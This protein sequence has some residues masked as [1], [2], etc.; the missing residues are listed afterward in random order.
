MK[1]IDNDFLHLFFSKH[2]L[3]TFKILEGTRGTKNFITSDSIASISSIFH[4]DIELLSKGLL[5]FFDQNDISLFNRLENENHD[6]LYNNI[7]ETFEM[8]PPAIVVL[9]EFLEP[10]ELFRN[11]CKK[12]QIP[13]IRI[14][15]QPDI[16]KK[17]ITIFLEDRFAPSMTVHG[18]LVE[19]Y[20]MGLLITGESGIGKSEAA[21][22]LIRRGHRLISDDIVVIKRMSGNFL[23]GTGSHIAQ[24]F[25]EVRGVGIINVPQLFGVAAVREKKRIDAKILL[26]EWNL[27]HKYDRLGLIDKYESILGIKVPVIVIPVRPGRNIPGIIETSALNLRLKLSGI[28]SAQTLNNIL[29]KWMQSEKN[30]D[31]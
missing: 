22:D 15:E 21:L 12:Y 2:N 13:L 26:E 24:H 11:L 29:V 19:V 31:L 25:M 9:P 4:K 10:P 6:S 8:F 3:L 16:L 20:G 17:L 5:Y 1:L 23:F 30:I 28:N 27:S 7:S 14:A 18:D